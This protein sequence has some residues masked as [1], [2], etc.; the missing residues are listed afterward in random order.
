MVP[1]GAMEICMEI[2]AMKNSR[3]DNF[4]L[5]VA[6]RPDRSDARVVESNNGV[7]NSSP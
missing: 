3:I 7:A 2:S 4:N 1:I 5:A 6:A